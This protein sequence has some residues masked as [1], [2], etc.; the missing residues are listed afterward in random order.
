MIT[1]DKKLSAEE[2]VDKVLEDWGKPNPDQ[3]LPSRFQLGY[4][5]RLNFFD[6][7]SINKCEILKVHFSPGKVLYDVGVTI[8]G[9]TN[10]TR[11]YNVDSVFVDDPQVTTL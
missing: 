1:S 11:I 10:Y 6:A 5:V 2:M 7:G 4:Q 3:L 8:S 9:N